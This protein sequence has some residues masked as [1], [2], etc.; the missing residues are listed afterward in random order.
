MDPSHPPLLTFGQMAN[1]EIGFSCYN[2][3]L[4]RVND[5]A[6]PPVIKL[7]QAIPE[8]E[9]LQL[10]KQPY[11]T[12][13]VSHSRDSSRSL[14]AVSDSSSSVFIFRQT[15]RPMRQVEQNHRPLPNPQ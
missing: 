5:N 6:G 3:C 10:G 11:R 15:D 13:G 12:I 14:Y 8:L 2:G 9:I 1:L 4:S 7:A